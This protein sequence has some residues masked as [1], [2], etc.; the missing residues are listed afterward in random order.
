MRAQLKFLDFEPDPSTLWGDPA[1]FCFGARMIVGPLHDRGEESFD[2]TVCTPE[3]L[4][5][6]CHEQGGLY[7]PRHHLV[8]SLEGFDQRTL[9]AWLEARVREAEAPTWREVAERLGRLGYWEFEDYTP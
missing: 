2:I 9:R 5:A 1:E 6:K 4:A 7:N 3:W 8:V